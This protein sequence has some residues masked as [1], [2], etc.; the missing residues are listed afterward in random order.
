MLYKG[1]CLEI[2]PT[3]PS[4]SVDMVFCDLPYGTT[5]CKWDSIIPLDKLWEQYHR[6]VKE[7][8]AIVLTSAQPFTTALISSDLPNFKYTMVFQKTYATNWLSSKKRPLPDH[9]D[10]CIFYRKQPKYNPQMV[11]T[12]VPNPGYHTGSAEHYDNEGQETSDRGGSLDRFPR[13]VLGPFPR[14]IKDIPDDL[15]KQGYK[16]HPTQKKQELID[17]FI[18]SFTDE[19]DTVMD[20]TMGS[21]STCVSAIRNNRK[22]IGIEMS[23]EYFE[24]AEKWIK[25]EKSNLNQFFA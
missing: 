14:A 18:R 6:I 21:G 10:I 8:G 5:A 9:E 17:F 15:K 23:D 25:I 24:L 16:M 22:Y 3:L 13:T 12:G 1:D 11:Y 19:G 4:G 7:N 20:N 2:M